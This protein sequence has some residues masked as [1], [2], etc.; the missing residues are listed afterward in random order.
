MMQKIILFITVL[1]ACPVF[2]Q[3]NLLETYYEFGRKGASGLVDEEDLTDEFY[4]SKYNVKFSQ[5]LKDNFSYSIKYQ[6]YN[7]DYDTSENLDNNFHIAG[8]SL[9]ELLYSKDTFSIKTGPDFEY[10]EKTYSDA[11][12]RNY[13]QIKFDLPFTFKK[14]ADWTLKVTGGINSYH[15]P[16]APTDQLKLNSKFEVSKKFFNEKLDISAFYKLQ[17]IERQKIANRLERTFGGSFDLKIDSSLMKG[18]EGGFEEGMDNTIIYEEREDSFDFKYLSWYLKTKHAFFDRLKTTFKYA[19]INRVYAD[20]N[21]NFNGFLFENGWSLR[22][23]ETK[24]SSLDLKFN[25][26]HKQFR[27]PYVSNPFALHNNT[28]SPE[29]EFAKKTDWKAYLG[30]DIKFY[31]F[32]AKRTNDKIYYVAKASIDKYLLKGDL[33]IG[34]DYRYTFKN[35]LHKLDITED[36]FRFRANYKF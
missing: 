14:E 30:S 29:I 33:A 5:K 24:E 31:D 13:E 11:R 2:A 20:F 35:F 19:D 4:Y 36:L 32:P 8:V 34:F 17:H 18:F 27:Y 26:L 22:A 6:Y 9:E 3:D 10:K 15:Y 7:K 1:M 16:D 21:H 28:I 23:I 25:Y 12:N